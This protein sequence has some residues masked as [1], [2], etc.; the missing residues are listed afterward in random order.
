MPIEEYR[1]AYGRTKK[2]F[3]KNIEMTVEYKN[4]YR[5]ILKRLLKNI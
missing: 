4:D 1:N 3:Q 2:L 5:R